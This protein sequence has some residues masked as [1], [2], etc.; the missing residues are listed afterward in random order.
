MVKEENANSLFVGKNMKLAIALILSVSLFAGVFFVWIMV[1]PRIWFPVDSA[2]VEMA[3]GTLRSAEVY[4]SR[5]GALLIHLKYDENSECLYIYSPLFKELSSPS[6]S[7]FIFQNKLAF[8]KE[9]PPSAVTTDD[10]VKI[11]NDPG[12]I[13]EDRALEFSISSNVRVRIVLDEPLK[14]DL[15]NQ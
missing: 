7:Q 8:G 1:W 12:L 9:D 14:L 15:P 11:E 3:G 5:Y 10:R 6:G 2:K 13:V 4:R